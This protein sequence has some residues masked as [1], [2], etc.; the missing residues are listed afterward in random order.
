MKKTSQLKGHITGGIYR[1][2]MAQE[3][4][5][6]LFLSNFSILKTNQGF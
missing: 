5:R 1:E 3:I 2:M 4:K 6:K